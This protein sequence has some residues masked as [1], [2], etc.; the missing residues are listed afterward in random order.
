MRFRTF[1][2]ILFALAVV[3]SVSYFSS[4]N[5]ELLNQR[6]ALSPAT[7]A[8][9]YGVLIVIFLAGFLPAVSVLLTQS[10][11]RDLQ[12]RRD[13]RLQREAKSLR[14][15]FRRAID[16]RADGQ[17]GKAAAELEA[18][19]AE[20]PE[21]FG[22]LLY[23]GEALREL[24]RADEAIEVH[25]RLSVLYPQGVAALY[26]LA[27]DYEAKDDPEVAEQIFDRIL[28]DFPG[29]GLSITRRR[30]DEALLT[31][32]WSLAGQL[33]ERV[34]ALLEEGGGRPT[35]RE[36]E[37][38]RGL[39]YE[40]AVATL[41]TDRHS[42]A[43]E[44]IQ[45]VLTEAPDF[46][47]ALI[48]RGEILLAMGEEESAVAAWRSGFLAEGRPVFLQRIED[49]FIERE[50][51]L[52]AIETLHELIGEASSDLL[53]RFFLGRLYYR[54]EMHDE[55]LRALEPLAAR[56][57]RSPT[58]HYLMG[59][60]HQR[61]GEGAL[62]VESYRIAL[63]QAGVRRTEYVCDSCGVRRD[64]W[65]DRCESCGTWDGLELDFEEETLSPEAL[66]VH[67]RPVWAV[68]NDG[69][70]A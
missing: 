64:D 70:G 52:H 44:K 46:L 60:I 21:N 63:R 6:F 19:L 18:L 28:R 8:P 15:G 1:A 3:V 32:H 41:A 47:P 23:Y 54:L 16:F 65:A 13:R 31:R 36:T 35:P 10:L 48:L 38:R 68:D 22:T 33:Q 49:H 67:E 7:S 55:A 45:A 40:A 42:E 62:A 59:R 25:R 30:R 9:L 39:D 61:R 53:P 14:G 4:Q 37:L 51:P 29:Q 57:R 12:E 20:Q 66:G 56:F 43:L 58:Y 5:E 27:K 69:A 50:N 24:G 2:S 11:K 34:D 26:E 17:W